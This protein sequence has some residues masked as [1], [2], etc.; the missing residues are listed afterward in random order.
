[1]TGKNPWNAFRPAPPDRTRSPGAVGP[2]EPAQ[3]SRADPSS[4]DVPSK[5]DPFS[6][7][8]KL[9]RFEDILRNSIQDPEVFVETVYLLRYL[10]ENSVPAVM[11]RAALV[12]CSL[13]EQFSNMLRS[14]REIVRRGGDPDTVRD[15][16]R[17][18]A[19]WI[20]AYEPTITGPARLKASYLRDAAAA[21]LRIEDHRPLEARDVLAL[22]EIRLRLGDMEAA[23]RILDDP[24]Y[25]P[26]LEPQELVYLEA[27]TEY[28][29]RHF[30]DI[31]GILADYPKNTSLDEKQRIVKF[32][33]GWHTDDRG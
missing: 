22:W 19:D 13:D 33:V 18:T 3:V 5:E 23:E 16:L 11:H 7:P 31:P 12:L 27:K 32:W 30:L 25:R 2:A 24:R 28:Y 20:L 29:R 6:A 1:M 21:I 8:W 10:T 26:L 9:D 15:A 14:L 4:F 17:K